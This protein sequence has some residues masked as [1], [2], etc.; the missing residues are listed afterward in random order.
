MG[1]LFA[2]EPDLRSSTDSKLVLRSSK[3]KFGLG[4]GMLLGGTFLGTMFYAAKPLFDTFLAEGAA[5][6]KFLAIFFTGV[7]CC[8]PLIAAIC[9]L[10][11]K[12]VIIDKSNGA[13]KL[14]AKNKVAFLEWG[15]KFVAPFKLAD[16]E[17]K[18]WKG[19]LNTASLK[20]Q[21]KGVEDRY[22]T[23]G[24]WFL[25]V[26]GLVLE[27]RARRDDIDWLKAQIETYFHESP[28]SPQV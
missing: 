8:Y 19:A 21:E 1:L 9:F 13:Y 20:A 10:F 25:E 3:K 11:E 28:H 26:S 17:V 2:L 18:N 12:L 4:M 27:R 15:K 7:V 14:V 16:L 24:H 23:R 6:D 22:A 5:F